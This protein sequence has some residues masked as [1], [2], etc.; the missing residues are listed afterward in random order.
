MNFESPKK[1][2]MKTLL[3][4]GIYDRK[5]ARTL[6]IQHGFERNG[7]K[8]EE[9]HVDPR[10]HR[11]IG[12][13]FKLA[14]LGLRARKNRYDMVIVGF[15]GQTVVLFARLLF[16]LRIVFDAFLSLYDSNVFDR[17]LYPPTSWRAN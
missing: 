9:C 7:W 2:G 16:G 8:V 17:K 14:V 1:G 15:P 10:I 3:Y 11:G 4:F 13:Y 5:Y 12:K 6:V